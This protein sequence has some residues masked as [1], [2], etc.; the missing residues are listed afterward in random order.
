MI[1][2]DNTTNTIEIN[3]SK[4]ITYLYKVKSIKE[5]N[6]YLNNLKEKYKDATHICYSYI[7]NGE[8]KYY[9]DGEPSGTGGIPILEVLKKNNLNYIVCF[10][11]R[12]FGGIKLGASGLLRAYSNSTSLCL[13]K[14]KIKKLEKLIKI[15]FQ[16]TYKENKLLENFINK[17]K[18]IEKI[19]DNKVSYIIITNKDFLEK[20]ENLN[21]SYNIIEKDII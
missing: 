2:E 6:D 21:I 20:L 5:V 14:T 18:I 1:I 8:I 13:K 17:E 7:I 19:Y 16:I 15:K 9:D 11:V 4:F 3:K 10:I 12:Y